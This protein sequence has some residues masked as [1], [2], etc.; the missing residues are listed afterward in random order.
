MYSGYFSV[1]LVN[2]FESVVKLN[3]NCSNKL[4]H[5]ETEFRNSVALKFIFLGVLQKS[6][7]VS[8]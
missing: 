2:L 8:K 3:E 5:C 1:S 6:E 4:S 7:A